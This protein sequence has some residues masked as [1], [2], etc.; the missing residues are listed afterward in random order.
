MPISGRMATSLPLRR[1]LTGNCRAHRR[2]GMLLPDAADGSLQSVRVVAGQLPGEDRSSGIQQRAAPHRIW[3]STAMTMAS[4]V[5][6]GTTA[7]AGAPSQLA[8]AREQ[9]AFTLGF[10]II[11]VPFGVAF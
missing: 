10:H 8:P 11:L 2:V 4:L 7:F 1:E 3:E 5:A 9:M 6:E